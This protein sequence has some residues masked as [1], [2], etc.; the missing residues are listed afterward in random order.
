MFQGNL[1][2]AVCCFFWVFFICSS[3]WSVFLWCNCSVDFWTRVCLRASST[4]CSET[5]CNL[6]THWVRKLFLLL[7]LNMPQTIFNRQD[8]DLALGKSGNHSWSSYGRVGLWGYSRVRL[9]LFLYISDWFLGLLSPI[10]ACALETMEG[11]TTFLLEWFVIPG[12]KEMDD[13]AVTVIKYLQYISA[14]DGDLSGN[15]GYINYPVKKA[16]S[17]SPPAKR[18]I[19]VWNRQNWALVRFATLQEHR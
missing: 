7:I 15:M 9:K 19:G 8:L 13:C 17:V 11:K 12:T 18:L 14:R 3:F 2:S 6:S 4:S 10:S 16:A 5:F 1:E